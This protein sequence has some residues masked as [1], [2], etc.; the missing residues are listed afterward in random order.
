MSQ[1][2]CIRDLRK[3]GYTVARIAREV[4]VDEKTVRKYLSME[5]FSPRIPVKEK[6]PS[7]LDKYKEQIDKW[8]EEDKNNWF[9]QHH[10]AQRV[11]DRLVEKYEDFDCSYPTVV[12]YVRQVR[13]QRLR[14]RA[15]QELVWHPGEAQGDFGD[16]ECYERGV[17]DM[18]HYLTCVFPY[19]NADF[20]QMFNGETG[21]C[22]CQG[23]QDIFEFTGGVFPLLVIDNATGAGRRM[24]EVIQESKLF[25]QFRA[26]YGFSVRFCNPGSGWEKGCVEN[27]V[28]T[29]R[30]NRFV[31]LPEFDD[32]QQYNRE[33][34]L[35]AVRYQKDVH[36]KKHV[37]IAELFE[38]DLKA[39]MPLPRHP[40]DVCR[41]VY[42]K[43]DG[44]GKVRVDGNHHYSTTPLNGGKEVLVGIRAHTIDIYDEKR[45]ILISHSRKFG[46]QRTDSVDYRTSLAVL[47]HNVG[48][49]PNS[50]VREMVTPPVRNYLDAL[51]RQ[52]LKDALRTMNLLSKRYSFEKALEAF[53][54]A[55]RNPGESPLSDAVV[56]A[57][58]MADMG[59]LTYPS[60]GPDLSIYDRFLGQEVHQ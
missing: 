25:K 24:G 12:R 9:K 39:L 1:V 23:L 8:L 2:N 60:P 35:Q 11:Y 43:A 18:K 51:D 40:F 48:A 53:S 55:V 26:H 14:Q 37:P 31:P 46:K 28:G 27:K 58:R 21:E 49:W 4:S 30:R 10:T 56:F 59:D 13:N 19:S 47:M 16:A 50:G 32:L 33:L 15:C 42:T 38:Q 44:Y 41:Y 45:E 36:Y 3:E 57:A 22:I 29:V 5:D 20:P 34:L 52:T 7:K 54:M 17:K 6:K